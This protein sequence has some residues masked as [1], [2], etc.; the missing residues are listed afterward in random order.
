M[1]VRDPLLSC[2]SAVLLASHLLLSGARAAAADSVRPNVLF[3]LTDD[4]RADTIRALG[5]PAIRTPALDTL[6]ERGFSFTSAYC[7]GS[8]APAVCRPSRNM[9]MSGRTYFRWEGP[10]A[11]GE[12]PNLPVSMRQ[13]GYATYHYGKRGNTALLIQDKFETSKYLK[14][15]AARTDGEPGKAIIDDAI[16]FIRN[17]RDERPFFMLLA[18][19]NPH[20][21]RIAARHYLDLYERERIPLPPNYLPVH[22]FDNGEMTVRDELL[23]PWPRTESEIRRH[24]HEY[25]ASITG[26]DHHI[27]RLLQAL[28]EEKLYDNTIIVFTSDN[29]LAIG[30]HGLMG[31]QSVYEHS[32]RVPLIL[33]GP[34]IPKGCSD[35][36][37]YLMDL[38]PT[39]CEM[40]GTGVPEG[41]DG[42]S[43]APVIQR[44]SDSVRDTAF[45]AYRDVQR[46]VRSGRWKLIRYPR[47]N[48]SQLFDLQADPHE[49]R[50][51]A[52][53]P[54]QAERVEE[55]TE[56]LRI[57]QRRYGDTLPLSSDAPRDSSFRPPTAETLRAMLEKAA[58]KSKAAN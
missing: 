34:R 7:F 32:A 19:A 58:P 23:A 41:L 21:P 17:G 37:V 4:Q 20:D 44:R 53:M 33:A 42:R 27:G 51:L 30:S 18:F 48:R 35:A 24:L 12:E 54:E 57:A 52:G 46:A 9:L 47:I 49:M 11:S 56:A 13:A 50:D 14:D 31:K 55:L 1:A 22:P 36:F 45:Y 38:Y 3:L 40:A 6:A 16:A 26:L 5:C 28:R 25:Y 39:L 8:N 15:D 29:G 2:I 43:L 10:Y